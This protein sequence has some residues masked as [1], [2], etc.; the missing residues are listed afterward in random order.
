MRTFFIVCAFWLII[1]GCIFNQ[2]ARLPRMKRDME[3][4][5]RELLFI[6]KQLRRIKEETGAY[7]TNDMGLGSIGE[8]YA[9]EFDSRDGYITNKKPYVSIELSPGG[10]IG[11]GGVPIIYEN[12]RGLPEEKFVH[13]PVSGKTDENWFVG[14][15]TGIYIYSILGL[16]SWQ[17]INRAYLREKIVDT[18]TIAAVLLCIFFYIYIGMRQKKR[19]GKRIRVSKL[20]IAFHGIIAFVIIGMLFPALNRYGCGGSRLRPGPL[21]KYPEL[22]KEYYMQGV[23]KEETYL[24]LKQAATVEDFSKRRE[25]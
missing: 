4:V 14:V 7:P 17:G 16:E 24:K 23:I 1:I 25:L 9:Q 12:R 6:A 8:K 18:A 5:N 22:I 11:L 2:D 20:S 15:D 10:L 3:G 13:S 19:Y 21:K